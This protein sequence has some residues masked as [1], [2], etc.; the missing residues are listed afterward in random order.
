MAEIRFRLSK[1]EADALQRDWSHRKSNARRAAEFKLREAIWRSYPELREKDRLRAEREA[2][3]EAR[4]REFQK[5]MF[6]W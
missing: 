4:H 6:G 3:D 1:A 2:H 5:R